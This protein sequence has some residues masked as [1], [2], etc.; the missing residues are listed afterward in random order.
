MS[1]GP[2]LVLLLAEEVGCILLGVLLSLGLA[3]VA[4]K[5]GSDCFFT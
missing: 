3:L 2:L 5:D 4:V 1:P